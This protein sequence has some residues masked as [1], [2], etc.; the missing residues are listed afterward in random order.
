MSF[1]LQ[2]LAVCGSSFAAAGTRRSQGLRAK[3]S[4]R[5]GMGYELLLA[6][7]PREG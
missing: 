1:C 2:S 7:W 4:A 3:I 5:S 6:P